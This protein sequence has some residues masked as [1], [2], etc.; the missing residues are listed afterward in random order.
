[1][2]KKGINKIKCA[3]GNLEVLDIFMALIVVMVLQTCIFPN[4]PVEYSRH[5]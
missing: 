3:G 5:V 2:F 4:H 1:M